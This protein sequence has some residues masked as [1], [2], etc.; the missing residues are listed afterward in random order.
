MAI[1]KTIEGYCR[2]LRKIV[3]DIAWLGG[4]L[5]RNPSGSVSRLT[6]I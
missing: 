2:S 6:R 5:L 4:E 1:P 3:A